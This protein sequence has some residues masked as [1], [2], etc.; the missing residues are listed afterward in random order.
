M[1]VPPAEL[2]IEFTLDA[3]EGADAPHVQ[4]AVE[5][6]GASGLAVQTGPTTMALSGAHDAVL[7][8]LRGVIDATVRGG[9]RTL[10]LRIEVPTESR[11]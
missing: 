2:T 7:D 9:G 6:A 11:A 5:A 1:P 4:A 10:E 3:A 8:A